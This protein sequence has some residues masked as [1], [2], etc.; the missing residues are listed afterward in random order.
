MNSLWEKHGCILSPDKNL[1]WLSTW[2]G[3]S[4]V[5]PLGQNGLFR[6][7]VTG[8]DSSNR[9][10]IGT[11]IF[12]LQNFTISG[13]SKNP[14]V[15]LGER[16]TFDENGTS[17][18]FVLRKENLY[19]LY[20]LGWI[21][22]IHVPWYNGL[23]LAISSDGVQFNKFSKAPIFERDSLDYLGVGSMF[24]IEEDGLLKMWYSRFSSWGKDICDHKHYYNIKYAESAD[25]I[26]WVRYNQICIDFKDEKYEYAIAKPSV[27]KL[28][29]KYFM[30][31][32]H[33]GE[34]Y[35][36]GF[37][38][39]TDGKLWKRYDELVGIDLSES[40]WD[41]EM[42]CYAYV[43]VSNGKLWMLYN[44]N[45]Y[46]STGLGI[47]SVAIT[48]FLDHTKDLGWDL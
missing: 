37:A 39:S 2:A 48:E 5:M 12:D 40:G 36:I 22:G 16:G 17:Y 4:C 6:V 7:Y 32:S 24:I 34:T 9:S 35:K 38:V 26:S 27:I 20:Y 44:G 1:D 23:G 33:R 47:A 29:D 21:K 30:W 8:K 13:L 43:F 3:A 46:G 14:I 42:L 25:G 41:S 19:Y 28:E 15:E 18:P 31:Y 10:R 45:N 11:F